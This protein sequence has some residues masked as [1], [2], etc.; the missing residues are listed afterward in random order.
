M[1]SQ[2]VVAKARKRLEEARRK[3]ASPKEQSLRDK[4]EAAMPK[5]EAPSLV[6]EAKK[7]KEPEQ[8]PDL[9]ELDYSDD[10]KSQL[11]RLLTEYREIAIESSRLEASKKALGMR[12]KLLLR[13]RATKFMCGE[14]RVNTYK[15]SK[16]TIKKEL[17]LAHN[18]A[19]GVIAACTVDNGGLTLKVSG[20]GL[21]ETPGS[22]DDL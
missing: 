22:G 12:V 2:S 7:R 14:L 1:P 8:L 6:P 10:D 16:P 4:M 19:P 13:E 3:S 21:P 11:A 17:L 20:G 18:V 15:S 9:R 5:P